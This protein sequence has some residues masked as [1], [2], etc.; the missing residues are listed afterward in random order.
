MVGPGEY[1]V[2]VI[3]GDQTLLTKLVIEKDNPGYLGR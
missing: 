3:A 1:L 2:E